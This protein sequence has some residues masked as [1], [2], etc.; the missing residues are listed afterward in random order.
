MPNTPRT[1]GDRDWGPPLLIAL[2]AALFLAQAS[3]RGVAADGVVEALAAARVGVALTVGVGLA[4]LATPR[5]AS[6]NE[7]RSHRRTYWTL[8]AVA[9]SLLAWVRGTCWSK[10][11]RSRG[12]SARKVGRFPRILRRIPRSL[13]G[14]KGRFWRWVRA[15]GRWR[16]SWIPTGKA[17]KFPW[18]QPNQAM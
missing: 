16:C 7:E 10:P 12:W 15:A 9:L 4:A 2:G 17:G 5:T 1:L 3:A 11:A 14:A 13:A 18:L 8:G 6:Q